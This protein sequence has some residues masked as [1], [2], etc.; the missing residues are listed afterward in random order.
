MSASA[1]VLRGV[2]IGDVFP[3]VAVPGGASAFCTVVKI[4]D[5]DVLRSRTFDSVSQEDDLC[6]MMEGLWRGAPYRF[7][8][9]APDECVEEIRGV[10][11]GSID[12]RHLL[13]VATRM[14]KSRVQESAT[15]NHY[16]ILVPWLDTEREYV[17][18]VYS[19]EDGLVLPLV[20]VRGSGSSERWL[21]RF[22]DSKLFA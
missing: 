15:H 13:V 1:V 8:T 9:S 14:E 4:R 6:T 7:R 16:H 5:D 19:A 12:P 18:F 22:K 2:R 10:W 3:R 11:S 21:Y 17:Y 20:F